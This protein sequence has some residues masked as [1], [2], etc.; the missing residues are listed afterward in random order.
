[1]N[2]KTLTKISVFA[3][4]LSIISTVA[5]PS[6]FGVPLTL[7]TFGVASCG[8]ILGKKQGT[9]CIIVYILL[10]TMGLPIFSGMSS[11][12]SHLLGVTGGF[13]FGFLFLA[14]FSGFKQNHIIGILFS[15]FGLFICHCLGILQ[16]S[17]ISKN[18]IKQS[19]FIVSFP[20]I[21]KD[22]ISIIL[23]YVCRNLLNKR[24][25]YLSD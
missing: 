14:F 10:G 11:G 17:F 2:I 15:L 20:Y 5:I 18:P 22:V 7:Q 4:V 8:F 16:F 24:I 3:A 12:L 13:I 23:A 25:K 21:L 19:F 9:M 6:P 1:M